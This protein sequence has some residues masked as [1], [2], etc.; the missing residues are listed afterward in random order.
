MVC[1]CASS[2]ADRSLPV[3]TTTGTSASAASSL[4][5]L[6]QLEAG[7]VGQAQVEHHAVEAAARAALSSASRAGA[8]A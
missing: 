5:L 6:Q 7:H 3:K 8:D 1:S 4:H 2:S